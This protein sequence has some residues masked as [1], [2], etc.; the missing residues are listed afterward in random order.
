[1]RDEVAYRGERVQPM[2]ERDRALAALL[3]QLEQVAKAALRMI[4]RE[5]HEH[6]RPLGD[7]ERR[8]ESLAAMLGELAHRI[9]NRAQRNLDSR[10]ADFGRISPLGLEP[11]LEAAPA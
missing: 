8:V 4:D 2:R 5:E 1:M 3:G 11:T 10:A 6:A 7:R 9:R